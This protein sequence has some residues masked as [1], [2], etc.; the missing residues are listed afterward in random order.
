MCGNRKFK[1]TSL[2]RRLKFHLLV[3]I[4]IINPCNAGDSL[5]KVIYSLRLKVQFFLNHSKV[6][7]LENKTK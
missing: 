1:V 7:L 4:L 6:Q 2:E 5:I 3:Y